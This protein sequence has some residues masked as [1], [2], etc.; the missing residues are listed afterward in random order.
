[1]RPMV[2]RSE[3]TFRRHPN[4]HRGHNWHDIW[5]RRR[6]NAGRVRDAERRF[7]RP[8]DTIRPRKIV[9]ALQLNRYGAKYFCGRPRSILN[10]LCFM[11]LI[12]VINPALRGISGY[13][14]DKYIE[15][16]YIIGRTCAF[17]AVAIIFATFRSPVTHNYRRHYVANIATD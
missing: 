16:D 9:C 14:L 2:Q 10:K 17:H 1:M 6:P 7:W 8:R 12:N 5:R 11:R 4:R 13:V 3:E 15:I